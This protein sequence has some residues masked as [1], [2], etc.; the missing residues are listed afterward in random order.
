MVGQLVV[1]QHMAL[2]RPKAAAEGNLLSRRDALVAVDHH[3]VVL[4]RLLQPGKIL[5][6][7]RAGQV[8]THNL[9]TQTGLGTSGLLDGAQA[10]GLRAASGA[11]RLAGAVGH[12]AAEE[13]RM[14]S[15]NIKQRGHG[16]FPWRT[17]DKPNV[18]AL[19]RTENE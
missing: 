14:G 9:D 12:R 7:Q 10:E 4:V 1:A 8:Q 2:Q 3:A 16:G 13:K 17:S 6:P 5:R 18:E 11:P 19:P 15:Q